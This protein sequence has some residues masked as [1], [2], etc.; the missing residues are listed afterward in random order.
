MIKYENYKSIG[1]PPDNYGE[2]SNPMLAGGAGAVRRRK[3]ADVQDLNRA[4]EG[5]QGASAVVDDSPTNERHPDANLRDIPTV[6]PLDRTVRSTAAEDEFADDWSDDEFTDGDGDV[7]DCEMM[8]LNLPPRRRILK[9]GDGVDRSKTIYNQAT[10]HE[11]G[12]IVYP[13]GSGAGQRLVRAAPNPGHSLRQRNR[14]SASAAGQ[15][16]AGRSPDSLGGLG[17]L[18]GGFR[19]MRRGCPG[20]GYEECKCPDKNGSGGPD[21]DE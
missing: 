3:V 10:E 16:G 12:Q 8:M 7:E 6:L 19:P 9:Y 15:D 11:A 20:C 14:G 18:G 17:G 4:D 13:A 21:G 2:L 1:Q 5:Q